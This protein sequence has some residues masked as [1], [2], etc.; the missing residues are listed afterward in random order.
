MPEYR[1]TVQDIGGSQ[2]AYVS[3]PDDAGALRAGLEELGDP[4]EGRDEGGETITIEYVG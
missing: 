4:L 1:V 2:T 3:A